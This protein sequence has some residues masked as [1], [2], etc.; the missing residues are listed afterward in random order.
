MAFRLDLRRLGDLPVFE[1]GIR[2]VVQEGWNLDLGALGE[3]QRTLREPGLSDLNRLQDL[4]ARLPAGLGA[5]DATGEV[6]T[7]SA[8]V[9]REEAAVAASLAAAP[10]IVEALGPDALSVQVRGQSFDVVERYEDDASGFSALRLR[11][12][13]GGAEVFAIDGLEVGSRADEVAAA[14]LGRIQV[15]SDAFRGMIADATAVALEEGREIHFTGPS[16]GGAV[17]QVAAHEAAEA[18]ALSGRAFPT[19]V[20]GLVTVD[21]LG[22]RDAAEAINGGALDPAALRLIEALNLRTEGDVVS[23]IGSHLGATL[24]LPALDAAGNRVTLDAA[25]AHVNV[26]SLLQVLDSDA[27]FAEGVAGA[28]AEISGFAR[29][30]NGAGA[31]LGQAWLLAGGRDDGAPGELQIPGTASFDATGTVWSLDADDD[32][33]VDIAVA[34]AQPVSPATADLVLG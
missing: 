18:L 6:P 10:R 28:P 7:G 33:S 12:A 19:G 13:A 17:A 32:G 22:G 16:L 26:V 21:A 5:P 25:D 29:A 2:Q 27:L 8:A 20:V 14:G 4:A 9:T 34:L 11:P 31:A 15:T 3:L 23:R 1:D 30:A 24:T